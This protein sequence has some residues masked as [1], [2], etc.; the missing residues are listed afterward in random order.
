MQTRTRTLPLGEEN[1]KLEETLTEMQEQVDERGFYLYE[2]ISPDELRMSVQADY[3]QIVRWASIPLAIVTFIFGLMGL[4]AGPIGVIGAILGVLGVFYGLLFLY[5]VIQMIRRSYLYTRG[6]DVIVT[7]D[8]YVSGGAI[9]EKRDFQGQ[10]E[11]FSTLER[12]FREPLFGSS[13]MSE[14][15]KMERKN[16]F[17]QLKDIAY[18]WGKI[19]EKVGRSRDSG[20][21]ILVVIAWGILYGMMMAGVYFVGVFFVALLARL[22]SWIAHTVLLAVNNLEYEIQNLFQKITESSISLK[23]EKKNTISLLT[24]AGRNEWAENL[25]W[26]IEDSFT[27]VNAEASNALEKSEKLRVFLE[28]SKYKNI[29]NF[30]KYSSWIRTQILEPIDEIYDLL[31]SNHEKI[32]D[33]HRSIETQ[34][35]ETRE[36]SLKHPLELQRDRLILQEESISRMMKMLEGYREKLTK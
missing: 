16:L 23:K 31:S 8:H 3:L 27:V 35:S 22:F 14:Y 6:A 17:A 9:V 19:I 13:G 33:T 11:A 20:A 25:K 1:S 15:M 30:Q 12:L 10:K 29:F 34:I 18:G 7:D 5:L 21:I 24:E 36:P 26:R 32:I 4:A 28:K 2:W